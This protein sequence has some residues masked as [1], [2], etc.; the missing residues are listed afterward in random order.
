MATYRVLEADYDPSNISTEFRIIGLPSSW[1]DEDES[2]TMRPYDKETQRRHRR[3]VGKSEYGHDFHDFE[4]RWIAKRMERAR[5]PVY[6]LYNDNVAFTKPFLVFLGLYP[7][8][9]TH[10]DVRDGDRFIYEDSDGEYE[11]IL[12][13]AWIEGSPGGIAAM[14]KERAEWARRGFANRDEAHAAVWED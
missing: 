13:R 12:D 8:T 6:I 2:F 3:L 10:D 1:D 14:E 5:G 11:F 4:A 9:Q 7:I